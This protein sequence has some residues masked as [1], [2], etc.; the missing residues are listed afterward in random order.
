MSWL[1]AVKLGAAIALLA[2]V[3]LFAAKYWIAGGTTDRLVLTLAEGVVYGAID[4]LGF[5]LSHPFKGLI[6]VAI[7]WGAGRLAFGH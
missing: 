7:V 4:T 3:L 5:V 6:Y 2:P 1:S